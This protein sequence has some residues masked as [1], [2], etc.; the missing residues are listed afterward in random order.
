MATMRDLLDSI[1]TGNPIDPTEAARQAMRPAVRRRFYKDVT[2]DAADGAFAVRLDGRPV[3]TPGRKVLAAPVAALAQALADEWAAQQ[4]VV[5]PTR[6]PLTRLANSI[7]DGVA[8]N[9][10]T[11]AADVANYAGS[12]LLFYRAEQPEGLVRSQAE[13]WDPVLAWAHEALGARFMLSQGVMFVAQPLR[14]LAAAAAAIPGD[15][16]RLGAVHA[17]TTLTG[18]A[19]LALAVARG[20]LPADAAWAAAHVDEDWQMRQWGED[21]L[22]MQRR[23]FRKRELDAAATVLRLLAEQPAAPA[24]G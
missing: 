21:E 4:D 2:V 15:P 14:A 12:D 20:H 23:G 11:V 6:M 10:E 16:W 1:A 9:A 3:R 18:S 8:A 24:A 22:A 7:I 17:I 13:H 19:L 5:D